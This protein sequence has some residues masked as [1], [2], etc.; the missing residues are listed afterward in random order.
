MLYYLD[1]VP[2]PANIQAY[3]HSNNLPHLSYSNSRE[4]SLATDNIHPNTDTDLRTQKETRCVSATSTRDFKYKKMMMA[5]LEPRHSYASPLN[6]Q[7]PYAPANLP[8]RK[9]PSDKSSSRN[10]NNNNNNVNEKD[11]FVNN[12]IKMKSKS[13]QFSSKIPRFLKMSSSKTNYS[14]GYNDR[15]DIHNN[16]NNNNNNEIYL[17]P[18]HSLLSSNDS[19]DFSSVMSDFFFT[20]ASENSSL[21]SSL[22]KSNDLHQNHNLMTLPHN[23]NHLSQHRSKNVT[24]DQ[25]RCHSALSFRHHH[26]TTTRNNDKL[27]SA[28]PRERSGIPVPAPNK[29][30]RSKSLE[31][32]PIHSTMCRSS[33]AAMAEP[34]RPKSSVELRTPSSNRCRSP[35]IPI[36]VNNNN[37]S[38]GRGN[39]R[40]SQ[41]QDDD[42]FVTSSSPQTPNHHQSQLTSRLYYCNTSSHSAPY[43]TSNPS[44]DYSDGFPSRTPSPANTRNCYSANGYHNSSSNSRRPPSSCGGSSGGTA[45]S[46]SRSLEY[47]AELKV[48]W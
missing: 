35:G 19:E 46:V 45:T 2:V 24:I 20:T 5:H 37:N 44:R 7:D 28:R 15:D 27:S 26:A 42:V 31:R 48:I 1:M 10:S 18:S 22:N 14:N 4:V 30:Y 41:Q 47:E 9:S 21:S 33:S 34:Q 17:S 43:S 12:N 13:S 40:I 6:Q 39:Q 11:L 38:R 25:R 23:N 8:L 29:K 32:R 36:R 3:L 16:N